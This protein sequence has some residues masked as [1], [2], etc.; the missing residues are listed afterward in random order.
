[1]YDRRSDLALDIVTRNR[2]LLLLK[3]LRPA[4]RRGYEFG[5]AVDKTTARI[6]RL[7]RVIP[8][9]LLTADG[10]IVDENLRTRIL[11]LRSYINRLRPRLAIDLERVLHVWRHPVEHRS[12]LDRDIHVRHITDPRRGVGLGEDRLAE[13]P[14]NLLLVDLECGYEVDV[15]DLVG[16]EARMHQPDGETILLRRTLPVVLD[17]LYQGA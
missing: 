6:Q 17:A 2:Q 1:M 10:K 16:S 9:T 7:L 3:L 5:D 4:L 14:S 11:Q 8:R 13:I 15:L 12:R